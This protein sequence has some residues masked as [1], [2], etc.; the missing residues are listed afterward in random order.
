MTD[1]IDFNSE[2]NRRDGNEDE[3]RWHRV[4]LELCDAMNDAVLR[5]K[6]S[7][8]ALISATLNALFK[9]LTPDNINESR[10]MIARA[11]SAFH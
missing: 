10:Q 3:A 5:E 8:T 9:T 2:R 11:L 6:I 4:H 7:D 1:I